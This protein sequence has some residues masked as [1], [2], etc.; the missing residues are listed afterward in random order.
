MNVV[1]GP[2]YINAKT[3]AI[4][5]DREALLGVL[6]V[7]PVNIDMKTE[8]E[9]N[10]LHGFYQ[11]LLDTVTYPI[12][13]YS[14]QRYTNLDSYINSLEAEDSYS[15]LR[16]SY[17]NLCESIGQDDVVA[18]DH[19]VLLRVS[20]KHSRPGKV[21]TRR[22][23]E[24]A[25]KLKGGHF[26]VRQVTGDE[27]AG[28]AKSVVN[29]DPVPTRDFCATPS[30][31]FDR[32]RK[33]LYV[34][35]YP[36]KLE[37]GW[38]RHVLRV[39]GLV[40]INQVI[41][42]VEESAAVKKLR[43]QSEKLDTE[44]T[45][46]LAHGHRGVNKLERSLDDVE[47]FL[48]LLARQ[49]CR[50][51][52][53]GAYITVDAASK[54]GAEAIC[55][56]V[57][58][59]LRALQIKFKEPA[60]RNDRAYYT[61]S[62]FY[63]DKLDEKMLMPSVS[64][65]VGFPFGTQQFSDGNGVL[66][67]IDIEDGVP[68]V[69]DRFGWNSH[70]MAVMGTL[71]YGKSYLAKLELLRSKLVYPDLKIFVADPKNEYRSVVKALGGESRRLKAGTDYRF[72][73]DVLGFEPRRRGEFEN[74]AA[75]VELVEQL[76]SNVSKDR[77]KTIVLIDECHNVLDEEDGRKVLNQFVLEARDINTAVHMVTQSASHFTRYHKGRDILNHVPGKVLFYHETVTDS[78]EQYFDLSD[79]EKYSIE[80]LRGG[81]NLS[82]SE[83]LLRVSNKWNT[84][85]KIYSTGLEH[86]IIESETKQKV[87]TNV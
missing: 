78:M 63:S 34:D 26:T 46:F 7:S 19:Y 72:D 68:I 33:L 49:E 80:R 81:K 59:R 61:D 48:D 62:P 45:T 70:S 74:F 35:E 67:G 12:S 8:S 85:I 18:T 22:Q 29:R 87:R 24:V 44:I 5:V 21:L 17:V 1:P 60:Y 13:I 57:K 77:E 37:F 20:G 50:P 47:W 11:E 84:R 43:R 75:L 9:K 66:Y 25:Q 83:A 76:Y 79:Q 23:K 41:R 86:Q 52:R 32:Y 6:K 40:N 10:A 58:A 27:L 39:D 15:N 64:A 31:G 16:A 65:A 54:Q 30:D 38:P 36:A 51:V 82:F 28:F 3:A 73:R 56:R 53:Y 42:P 69:L 4:V 71:G 55:D 2:R 14:R